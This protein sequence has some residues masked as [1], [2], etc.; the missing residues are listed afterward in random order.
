MQ[1]AAKEKAAQSEKQKLLTSQEALQML[2]GERLVARIRT[3][4]FENVE[5]LSNAILAGGVRALV[6]SIAVPQRFRFIE[7]LSQRSENVLVGASHVVTGEQAQKAIDAGA[8]FVSTAFLSKDVTNVCRNSNILV[9]QGVQ[10]PTEIME[11]FHSGADMV[12]LFPIE[13]LGGP[14]YL[15]T[16]REPL[17]T[18]TVKFVA[19]GGVSLDNVVDYLKAGASAVMVDEAISDRGLIRDNKWKD[20]TERAKLFVEK[21]ASLKTS[22]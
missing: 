21:I 22:K 17:P 15:R 2:E 5:E 13:F 9:I 4:I 7:T 14:N 18:P 16:I 11:A 3:S 6:I 12:Q 8:K 19:G 1:E 20:I 10:T